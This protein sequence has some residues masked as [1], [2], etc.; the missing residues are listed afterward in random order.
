MP[1]G[2][3]SKADLWLPIRPNHTVVHVENQTGSSGALLP[4]YRELIWL[5]KTTP[6]LCRGTYRSLV[7][8]PTEYLSYVHS[9]GRQAVLV[10]L[11]FVGKMFTV[12]LSESGSGSL[13]GNWEVLF[14]TDKGK[15]TQMKPWEDMDLSGYEVLIL[16][17]TGGVG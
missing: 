15:G 8:G 5:R 6:A 17:R 1:Y 2:G 3:F 14:G 16:E 7:T 11:N 13:E 12:K 10:F 9:H 4:F